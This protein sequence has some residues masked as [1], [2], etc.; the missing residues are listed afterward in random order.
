MGCLFKPRYTKNGKTQVSQVWW[1][2]FRSAGRLIRESTGTREKTEARRFLRRREGAVAEGKPVTPKIEKIKVRELA[3]DLVNEYTANERPSIDRLQYALR[4]LLPVFGEMRAVQ[5]KTSDVNRYITKRQEE[6]AANGTINRELSTLKRMFS[7]AIAAEK[8]HRAPMIKLLREDNVRKGF[9]EKEHLGAVRQFLPPYLRG[10]IGFAY[11]TGWRIKSE[12]LPLRWSQVDFNSGTVRLDPGTTKN[13]EGRTFIMTPALRGILEQQRSNADRVQREQGR[14]IPHVFHR[15][16]EP[17]KVIKRAWRNAVRRAGYPA[18]MPH[19]LRRSAVR[20]ME[21]AGVPRS[22]AMQM[23]GHK[24]EVMYRRYAIVDEVMM[25]EGAEKL[26]RAET[27]QES[28]QAG[29]LLPLK[30]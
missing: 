29:Q 3:E 17:I 20:N 2:Q 15:N 11:V 10:P 12:V 8:M 14:I 30:G 26:A 21:R 16:G 1:A 19:D 13:R 27:V 18:L 6:G 25:R 9:F 24:T 28:V 22:V 4:H 23:V 5:V 7:L